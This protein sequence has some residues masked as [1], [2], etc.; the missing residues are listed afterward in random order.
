[1]KKI[2]WN[3]VLFIF[4][5]LISGCMTKAVQTKQ[6]YAQPQLDLVEKVEIVGV[7]FIRQEANACGPATLAMVLQWAGQEVAVEQLILQVYSDSEKG[8]LPADMISASRRQGMM[9]VQIEGLSSLL[10]ELEAGHPVIVFE[11]LGVKWWPQWHYAIVFGYDLKTRQLLLHSG[12]DSFKEQKMDEFELSWRLGN[13]WGLVVL[14]PDELAKTADELS[15]ASAASALENL[16]FES[17]AQASYEAIL[18]RWPNSLA[19]YVGLGNISYSKKMYRE[20]VAYLKKAVQ[21]KPE[22]VA[23]QHNLQIAETALQATK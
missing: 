13:Y 4:G 20:S 1:M 21:L 2:I 15:H 23:A 8:S 18:R 11:N 17:E 7:P 5:G 9:A 12:P 3:F 16:G 22:S 14:P 10:K 6:L 19:A